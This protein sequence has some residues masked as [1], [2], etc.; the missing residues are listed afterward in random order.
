MLSL[1]ILCIVLP[2]LAVFAIV[3]GLDKWSK[4]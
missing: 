2:H 3:V 1:V 4:L